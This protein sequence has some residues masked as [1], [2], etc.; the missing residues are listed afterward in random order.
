MSQLSNKSWLDDPKVLLTENGLLRKDGLNNTELFNSI[1]QLLVAVLLVYIIFKWFDVS[2]YQAIIISI[3][4]LVTSYLILK[5]GQPKIVYEETPY[6][7]VNKLNTNNSTIEKFE[8]IVDTSCT[9]PTP[10]NPFMNMTV[11]D[12]MDN[13]TRPP[14]CPLS[15]VSEKID[16]AFNEAI[17]LPD[18]DDVFNRRNSTRQFYTTPST[19][20][21]NDQI[22]FAKWLYDLPETCKENQMNCL[23]Y[24][25][26]RFSRY[27]P[28]IDKT[29]E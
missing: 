2:I 3:L 4:I 28:S 21:P 9:L 19:T 5:T 22:S 14:A 15:K 24:E 7:D 1:S 13:P 6:P 26:I 8:E 16:S 20:V 29:V 17:F 25:D 18:V 11:A 27:N 23:R 10:N 12:L